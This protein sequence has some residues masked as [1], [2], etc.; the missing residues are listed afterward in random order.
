MHLEKLFVYLLMLSNLI[1]IAHSKAKKSKS[2]RKSS[3]SGSSGGKGKSKRSK[4]NKDSGDFDPSDKPSR[5][6]L[7]DKR[8]H[9]DNDRPV[10]GERAFVFS[11]HRNELNVKS[12]D[13]RCVYIWYRVNK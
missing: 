4:S 6:A 7:S 12:E 3:D 13:F 5:K 10:D 9:N 1:G 11:W 8:K 2:G